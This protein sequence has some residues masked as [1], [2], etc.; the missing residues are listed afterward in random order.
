MKK[1]AL[2][3]LLVLSAG[4]LLLLSVRL[5]GATRQRGRRL[6]PRNTEAGRERVLSHA[7]EAR[8]ERMVTQ[9]EELSS[10]YTQPGERRLPLAVRVLGYVLFFAVVLA[11]GIALGCGIA[12]VLDYLVG[13]PD[14]RWL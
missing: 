12:L 4:I 7:R 5:V 14:T 9:R 13:W 11:V 1:I 2:F 3:T 10:S 8:P 6:A